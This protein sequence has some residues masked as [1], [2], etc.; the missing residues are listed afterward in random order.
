VAAIFAAPVLV[1]G[2][3]HRWPWLQLA[4][5]A[6]VVFYCGAP[7]YVA[8]W[9]ALR[10][11]SAN[12]NSLIA[13]GTGAAFLYSLWETLHG[14]H[15]VYYEAAAAIIALILL[16]R[17]LEA[18]ARSQAGAAIRRLMDLQP[19]AAR[20]L[21]EGVEVELPVEDVRAATWW[22]CGPGSASPWMARSRAANRRWT[23][24]C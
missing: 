14:G 22:W 1:L 23:N 6:P 16:G 5:T 17:T 19:A 18:R 4:L 21:R 24:R 9:R 15:E 10:H 3:S 2:M 8:A 7:F 11:F 12:M 20:V 13:L